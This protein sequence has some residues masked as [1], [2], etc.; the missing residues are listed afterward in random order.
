MVDVE[1]SG[2]LAELGLTPL[3]EWRHQHLHYKL[4]PHKLWPI[5]L[6]PCRVR[7]LLVTDAGGSFG[8]GTFGL[9]ALMDALA[10]PPG[11]W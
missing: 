7:I 3:E 1:G 8:T 4:F 2:P 6:P 11:P 9:K 10:V 5:L